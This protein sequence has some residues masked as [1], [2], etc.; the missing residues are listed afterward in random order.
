MAKEINSS[1]TVVSFLNLPTYVLDE[2]ITR[3][4]QDWGVTVAS[5]IKRRMWPGTDI[6]DGTRFLKVKFTDTVKSLPYSTKFETVGGTEH[7]RVIHD[8][9]V[10]VCRLCI[11]PGHIVRDCPNFNCFKCGKQGHYA[12]ECTLGNCDVCKLKTELCVCKD[13]E[14][15]NK[16]EDMESSTDLY[17]DVEENSVLE[18]EGRETEGR[19]MEWSELDVLEA[20]WTG[21]SDSSSRKDETNKEVEAGVETKIEDKTKKGDNK[22]QH[23]IKHQEMKV[24]AMMQS[25]DEEMTIPET[26]LLDL[27]DDTEMNE[28]SPKMLKR[29][30]KGHETCTAK[31]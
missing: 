17:G 10:K 18:D 29:K 27:E 11:Q 7:F 21:E 8:R 26:P 28:T 22:K 19:E 24:M 1:E 3:K 14:D 15:E 30:M 13:T 31:K 4:L 16:N 2:E 12:R 20:R 25:E 9:Q 5:T 6:A 23:D